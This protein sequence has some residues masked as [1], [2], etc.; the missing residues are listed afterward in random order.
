M[1]SSLVI[2]LRHLQEQAK[3][4]A[5][6]VKA[7]EEK[8]QQKERE[9]Q[10]KEKAK[11]DRKRAREEKKLAKEAEKAEKAKKKKGIKSSQPKEEEEEPAHPKTPKR[12]APATP[13]ETEPAT[14]RTGNKARRLAVAATP[15]QQNMLKRIR[16]RLEATEPAGASDSQVADAKAAEKQ[17][18]IME[19]VKANHAILNKLVEFGADVHYF[20]TLEGN[21]TMKSFTVQPYGDTEKLGSNI[22][23]ILFRA[24]FYV[25]KAKIPEG[26]K[27]LLDRKGVSGKVTTDAGGGCSLG[28]TRFKDVKQ[29]YLS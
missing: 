27:E 22:G 4:E 8:K 11:E 23:C 28:W 25:Y 7:A 1:P 2:C 16:S 6:K 29:A 5:A 13:Q 15:R 17:A 20:P 19:K 12:S 14:P 18:A 26:F 3:A 10:E 9:K 24:S 21:P